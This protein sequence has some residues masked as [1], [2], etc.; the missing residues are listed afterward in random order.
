MSGGVAV[1][2]EASAPL[3]GLTCMVLAVVGF[4]IMAVCVKAIGPGIPSHEK[5]FLRTI[6]AVP[7][8]F[9]LVARAGLDWRGRRRG[10]LAARGLLGFLGMLGY[11]VAIAKLPL[12]NAVLLTHASPIFSA[13]FAGRF[14][15]ERAGRAVWIAT[16]VC[17]LGV[18]VVARPTPWAPPLWS[19]LALVSAAVNGATYTVV[20]ATA[21]TEHH[22]VVALWLPIVCLPLTAV[23]CAVEWVAPDA[24]QWWLIGGMT[25]AS[26]V[27]QILMTMGFHRLTASRAT[28][29]FFLGVVLALCWQPFLDEAPLGLLD[30]VGAAL[31]VGGI[32]GLAAA[33][34][35]GPTLGRLA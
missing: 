4:S 19:A 32:L 12:G 11:F 10:L 29:V 22:L 33:R 16:A 14:L 34:G 3:S 6:V 27:A 24:R 25:I 18:A 13:W 7:V 26:I 21:K 35:R 23:L 9:W 2:R 1:E 28:N 8:M 5:I 31:V 17:L 15:G 20:R 30:L